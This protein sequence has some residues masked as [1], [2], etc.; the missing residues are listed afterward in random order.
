MQVVMDGVV[1]RDQ[2]YGGI[3]RIFREILPRMCA[4]DPHLSIALLTM[5]RLRQPLPVHP[6]LHHWKL[7]P[8]D[9]MMR[10]WRLWWPI[11][12][13]VRMFV[14]R[15]A[16][17]PAA[18]RLWHSTYYTRVPNWD[19]PTV[20]TVYDLIYER[21]PYLFDRP[22]DEAFRRQ[23]RACV[24][25]ADALICI[26]EAT[27]AEVLDYYGVPPERVWAVPL[28]ASPAFRPIPLEP[29]EP[30]DPP[31]ILFVGGR[32]HYKNFWTLVRAYADWAARDEVALVVVGAPPSRSEVAELSRLGVSKRVRWI[33][34]ADDAMLC[35]LYNRAAAFVYPSLSEGFGIPLLEAL[36]CGCPVVVSRIAAAEEVVGECAYYFDANDPDGLCLALDAALAEGRNPAAV[37]RR[38]ARA[39]RFSWDR[40]AA[41]TLAIYQRVN[42]KAN[43]DS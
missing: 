12:D 15:Q 36:A 1:F 22:V 24:L 13:R 4:L 25:E 11:I 28:A 34:G 32:V 3:S 7:L 19:G 8:V 41:E 42:A 6:R 37:S 16:L 35:R 2:R 20:V 18:G 14:Q 39:A 40:T 17:G 26:S 31:F 33:V 29:R 9:Q 21:F 30:C 43:K 10:P 38:L 23:K 5:G 27:R